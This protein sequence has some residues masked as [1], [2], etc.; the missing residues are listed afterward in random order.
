MKTILYFGIFDKDFS[1]N[2]VYA[3]G[4]GQHGIAVL[5]C[6]DKSRGPIKFIKLFFKLWGFRGR[7]DAMIVGYPGYIVVPFARL[8]S[9]L[10][11]VIT[12]SRQKPILFDALCSFYESQIIS[13]DA[14][15]G[16][17]FRFLYV[18]TVDWLSTRAADKILVETQ[19]QK[20]YFIENL[21]VSDEKCIVVYTGVDETVF[22]RDQEVQKYEKFTV[23]FRGR[24]TKEAGVTTILETAKILEEKGVNFLIV[25]FGWG[26][27]MREFDEKMASLKLKNL[28]HKKEQMSYL[29]LIP[30]ISKCHVSL[31][32]FSTNERLKRTIPH[33]AFEALTMKIPYI[34]ARGGA[35]SEIFQDGLNCIMTNPADAKDLAEKVLMIQ[36][37]AQ[38]AESVVENGFKIFKEKLTAARIVE[39]IIRNI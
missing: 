14:Y 15:R 9:F 32:Q 5:Y 29:E 6:I 20:D 33:K 1:R 36:D 39:P 30:L 8:F 26:S 13:R 2:K 28:I 34:T 4:L 18:R 21:G 38:M 27:A 35:V 17:P 16:N 31:G 19:A 37:N 23:L 24:I 12:F 11:S 22:V 3:N 7:Y 10:I 25:G